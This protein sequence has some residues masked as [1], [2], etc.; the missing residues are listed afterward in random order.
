MSLHPVPKWREVCVEWCGHSVPVSPWCQRGALYGQHYSHPFLSG[1]WSHDSPHGDG[2]YHTRVLHHHHIPEA[3]WSWRSCV[4]LGGAYHSR[5]ARVIG[6]FPSVPYWEQR[7]RWSGGGEGHLLPAPGQLAVC[8]HGV[9]S[10]L[11]CPVRDWGGDTNTNHP[12]SWG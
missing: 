6:A 4:L 10:C 1:E 2:Q 3:C 8:D 5:V 11:L 7:W 9:D 12:V